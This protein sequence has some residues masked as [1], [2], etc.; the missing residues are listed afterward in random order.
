MIIG[1][2]HWRERDSESVSCTEKPNVRHCAGV[3]DSVPPD[4]KDNPAGNPVCD[5]VKGGENAPPDA[6]NVVA[7]YATPLVPLGTPVG[8]IWTNIWLSRFSILVPLG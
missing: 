1:K 5:Q 8:V 3:P 2:D 6:V 7:A 4:D